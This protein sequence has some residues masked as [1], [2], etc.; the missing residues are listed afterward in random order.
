LL[1]INLYDNYYN[2]ISIAKKLVTDLLIWEEWLV[3]D[4]IFFY[5]S[6]KTPS[7]GEEKS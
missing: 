7:M 4:E 3:F 2:D 1:V 6:E 5:S